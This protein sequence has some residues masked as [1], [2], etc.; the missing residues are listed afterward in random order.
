[1]TNKFILRV[2]SG[3]NLLFS[4]V[5]RRGLILILVGTIWILFGISYFQNSYRRFSDNDNDPYSFYRIVD[6]RYIGIMWVVAGLIALIVGVLRNKTKL[7]PHDSLG[8]NAILFPSIIWAFLYFWSWII[9][10]GTNGD[11]GNSLNSVG[12]LV[13]S[14]VTGFILIIAGWPDPSDPLVLMVIKVPDSDPEP[15]PEDTIE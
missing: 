14:L 8:F 2:K 15:E 10:V 1:M 11:F 12:F 4:K 9:W 3:G 7:V 13:W 6:N 5:G